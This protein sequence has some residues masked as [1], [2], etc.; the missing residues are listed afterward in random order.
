MSDEENSFNES[1]VT[2][3]GNYI[4]ESIQNIDFLG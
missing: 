4:D 1:I 2:G 3:S